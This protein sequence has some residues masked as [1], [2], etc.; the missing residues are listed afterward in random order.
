MNDTT[1]PV[2]PATPETAEDSAGSLERMVRRL[3]ETR[4]AASE[5]KKTRAELAAKLGNCVGD[6]PEDSACYHSRKP[7]DHWCE[8]CK[9]KLPVWE[10]YQRKATTAG[11]ALRD[12]IRAG[13]RMT[14]NA[15]VS[16]AGTDAHEKQK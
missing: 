16:H 13:K 8:I 5:A 10:D 6:L 4:K 7:K 1:D 9:A 2:K 15:C 11:A 14:P 3:Y 12:V